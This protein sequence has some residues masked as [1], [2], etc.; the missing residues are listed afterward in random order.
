MVNGN[1]NMFCNLLRTNGYFRDK[2]QTNPF[3]SPSYFRSFSSRTTRIVQSTEWL[4]LQIWTSACM[5]L[6]CLD[7]CF[8]LWEAR[9]LWGA[10]AEP[11]LN[12]GATDFC[13][14]I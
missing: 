9:L 1:L 14:G 5:K 3:L 8:P 10:T 7:R 2:A 4:A 12:L 13:A 6:P 11:R